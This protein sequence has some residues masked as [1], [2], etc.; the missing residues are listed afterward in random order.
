MS[1]YTEGFDS[2]LSPEPLG[3]T[4][5]T[6]LA[7]DA[8]KEIRE[9]TESRGLGVDDKPFRPYSAAYA[10]YRRKHGR[11]QMVNLSFTGNMLG[12]LASGITADKNSARITL[13]GGEGMKAW[14]L[15]NRDLE[16]MGLSDVRLE[17][18]ANKYGDLILE[19]Y[20]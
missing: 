17:K 7:V 10:A 1:E 3:S 19:Q 18:L 12:T 5:W 11:T 20:K 14:A 4:A 15:E 6:Q 13:S 8:A 9:R 2:S 16:F